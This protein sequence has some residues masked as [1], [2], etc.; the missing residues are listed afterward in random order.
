[1]HAINSNGKVMLIAFVTSN[2]E[3]KKSRKKNLKQRQ[4]KSFAAFII[5]PFTE[6]NDL[7]S[8][9]MLVLSEN[10]HQRKSGKSRNEESVCMHVYMSEWCELVLVVFL[11]VVVVIACLAVFM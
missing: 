8:I 4:S 2:E 1:M 5:D 9:Y 3:K 11:L 10:T 6:W 7:D